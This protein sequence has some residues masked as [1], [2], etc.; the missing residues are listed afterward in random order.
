[1]LN[2]TIIKTFI[3]LI[4]AKRIGLPV[5]RKYANGIIIKAS[6]NVILTN[7]LKLL[8]GSSIRFASSLLKLKINIPTTIV[9]EVMVISDVEK[10]LLASLCLLK[11]LKKE[12]SIP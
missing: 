7:K 11:N 5:T 9:L 2:A 3:N 10:T 8:M 6:I 1:M 12:V 4:T